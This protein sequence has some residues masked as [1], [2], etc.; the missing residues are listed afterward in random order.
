M[1]YGEL[2]HGLP[3]RASRGLIFSIY[4]ARAV[5]N[6]SKPSLEYVASQFGVEI[7]TPNFSSLKYDE[8]FHCVDKRADILRAL[9]MA[10]G[11][12]KFRINGLN[13]WL[14]KFLR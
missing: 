3:V 14:K 7:A 2:I 5:Q 9:D 12:R 1:R 13:V 4:A 6:L 8:N 10:I 11:N